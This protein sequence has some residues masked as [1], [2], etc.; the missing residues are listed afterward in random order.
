[1]ELFLLELGYISKKGHQ[2]KINGRLVEFA[3][4]ILK[5]LKIPKQILKQV[6]GVEGRE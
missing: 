5:I 1:M 6:Y 4:Q 3:G 2:V